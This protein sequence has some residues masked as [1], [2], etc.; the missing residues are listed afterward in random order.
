M[1]AHVHAKLSLTLGDPMDSSLPGSSVHGILQARILE[2][3]TT[4]TPGDLPNPGIEPVSLVSSVLAGG[5]FTTAPPG[6]S[7]YSSS[8][9]YHGVA[10]ESKTT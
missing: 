10:K 6:N 3:V 8:Y 1:F 9:C 4:S 5:F 7:W 2:W